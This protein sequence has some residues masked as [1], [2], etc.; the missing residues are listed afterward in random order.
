MGEGGATGRAFAFGGITSIDVEVGLRPHPLP[1]VG[2]L[3]SA[4][5]PVQTGSFGQEQIHAIVLHVGVR[6]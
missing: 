4:A 1:G 3:I 6:G 2:D 5:G